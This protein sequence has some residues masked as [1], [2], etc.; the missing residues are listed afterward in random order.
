MTLPPPWLTGRMEAPA[1]TKNMGTWTASVFTPEQQERLNVT[2][3]GRPRPHPAAV[4][5][6]HMRGG[7]RGIG[8]AWTR[9]EIEAPAGEQDMGGWIAAVYTA[10]QQ[11]RLGVDK[12]GNPKAKARKEP[13]TVSLP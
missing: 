5:P 3:D 13:T 8:P 11:E 10:E 7:L 9:G 2:E 12:E 1:G 4:P 6:M